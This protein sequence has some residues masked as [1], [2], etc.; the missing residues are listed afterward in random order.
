MELA[1]G[2]STILLHDSGWVE[3][4]DH[5]R[6]DVTWQFAFDASAAGRVYAVE[7][8]ATDDDGFDQPFATIGTLA[9]G[10]VCGGDCGG[11]GAVAVNELITGV[12]IALGE[13]PF[14]RCLAIDVDRDENVQVSDLVAAVGHALDGCPTSGA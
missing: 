7:A 8:A 4:A 1:S 3:T 13:V 9:V 12:G 2:A 11:D 10:N 6:V 5:M 14:E